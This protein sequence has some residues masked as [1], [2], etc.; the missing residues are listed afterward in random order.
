VYWSR[1]I[2]KINKNLIKADNGRGKI[3]NISFSLA[4]I[5]SMVIFIA[6]YGKLFFSS[7]RLSTFELLIGLLEIALIIFL[8]FYRNSR[9]TWL[10]TAMIFSA[11]SGYSLFW[12]IV[13]LP[14]SCMGD[15]IYVPPIFFLS[16]DLLFFLASLYMAFVL[17]VNKKSLLLVIVNAMI[18]MS[19]GYALAQLIFKQMFLD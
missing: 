7:D 13:Q 1:F 3:E 4:L 18:F 9:Q 14:C 19:G 17:G 8:I 5:I 15:S 12:S 11:W 10:L 16:V 6:A 2:A